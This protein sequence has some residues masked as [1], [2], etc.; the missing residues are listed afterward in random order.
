V[1]GNTQLKPHGAAVFAKTHLRAR[2]EIRLLRNARSDK[3]KKR[4]RDDACVAT[5]LGNI[6]IS[7]AI[8]ACTRMRIARFTAPTEVALAV[9]DEKREREGK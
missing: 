4:F 7:V 9:R 5:L 3:E 6:S 8:S 1:P 2:P